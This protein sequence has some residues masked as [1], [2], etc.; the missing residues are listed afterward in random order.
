MA[1]N[2]NAPEEA[3]SLAAVSSVMMAGFSGNT[4]ASDPHLR[5][6]GQTSDA[7]Y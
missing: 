4:Q 6:S 3:L 7:Y 2:A 5:A 1:S